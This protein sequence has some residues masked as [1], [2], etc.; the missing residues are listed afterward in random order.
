MGGGGP[1]RPPPR[2][3]DCPRKSERLIGSRLVTFK[4]I[5]AR[6]NLS[7]KIIPGSWLSKPLW[8]SALMTKYL[9][10]TDSV[11]QCFSSPWKPSKWRL[12]FGLTWQKPAGM[13]QLLQWYLKIDASR[14]FDKKLVE[15]QGCKYVQ[16]PCK[17]TFNPTSTEMIFANCAR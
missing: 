4:N 5:M 2:W 11:P 6:Y 16:L 3:L 13:L 8:T 12:A 10:P 1:G 17:V 14:Y 7:P 9:L 15:E